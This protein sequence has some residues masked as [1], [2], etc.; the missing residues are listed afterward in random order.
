G[1]FEKTKV[2]RIHFPKKFCVL[3][4][5][6]GPE[7][8]SILILVEEFPCRTRLTPQFCD[9]RGDIHSE[10]GVTVQRLRN[11]GQVHG[12]IRHMEP[13]KPRL[14]MAR[15][16]AVACFEQLRLFGKIVTVKRPVGM[17]VKFFVAL[18]V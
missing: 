3:W 9:S 8:D 11:A 7:Y 1:G 17:I 14:W 6:V 12:V 2:V 18:V 4:R 5:S 16:D 10:V 15:D 13:D